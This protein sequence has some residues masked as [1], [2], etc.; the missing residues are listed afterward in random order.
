[1]IGTGLR[2]RNA[3]QNSVVQLDIS[4]PGQTDLIYSLIITHNGLNGL[5]EI[6]DI[7]SGETQQGAFTE[8][9][10]TDEL[11]KKGLSRLN[12][13][14]ACIARN[15]C[16]NKNTSSSSGGVLD[17][18]KARTILLR[19]LINS[20]LIGPMAATNFD[21]ICDCLDTEVCVNNACVPAM[22][23]LNPDQLP[24]S[25]P[26]STSSSSSG[27]GDIVPPQQPPPEG[28]PPSP[29]PPAPAP[30]LVI[31]PPPPP[32][33]A[34]PPIILPPPPPAPAP[35]PIILPPPPPIIILPPPPPAPAPPPLILPPPPPIILLPPPPPAPAPPPILLPPPPGF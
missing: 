10:G 30:P 26:G 28:G 9:L 31:L 3:S 15:I 34:P 4:Q 33:P 29:P 7:A 1:M 20:R 24:S 11:N 8:L 18:A 16:T 22:G 14:K 27:G 25:S 17:A 21:S 23:G 13:L 35:P 2:T 32:A 19:C 12:R 6:V 5:E